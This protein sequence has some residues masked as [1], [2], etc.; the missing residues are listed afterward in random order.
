MM[1]LSTRANKEIVLRAVEELLNNYDVRPS[2][3]G[4]NEFAN[5]FLNGVMLFDIADSLQEPGIWKKKKNKPEKPP[6]DYGSRIANVSKKLGLG[7]VVL[8]SPYISGLKDGGA[9]YLAHYV[10]QFKKENPKTIIETTIPF[11]LSGNHLAF[12]LKEK[13]DVVSFKII[14]D[15]KGKGRLRKLLR[16]IKTVRKVSKE[17]PIRVIFSINEKTRP[18]EIFGALRS[19][20]KSGADMVVLQA[21]KPESQISEDIFE[22]YAR[23]AYNLGFKHVISKP[24]P[25]IAFDLPEFIS[26]I[27]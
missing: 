16:A 25:N 9:S 1:P 23:E 6:I 15:Q 11:E 20:R 13:P 3:F 17:K 19:I 18:S 22:T 2:F 5:C 26:S 8:S 10:K 24:K 4:T 14:Y 12:L 21:S 7:Y 27:M